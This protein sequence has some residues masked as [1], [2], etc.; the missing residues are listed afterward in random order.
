V[1]HV[2]SYVQLGEVRTWG[3]ARA[4]APNFGSLAARFHVYTPRRDRPLLASVA[5]RKKDKKGKA[6]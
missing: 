6:E 3:D 4:W 2:G 1:I 5:M